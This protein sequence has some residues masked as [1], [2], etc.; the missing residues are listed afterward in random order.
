LTLGWKTAVQF[1]GSGELE[2]LNDY[3]KIIEFLVRQHFGVAVSNKLETGAPA[4]QATA[5]P[6][7]ILIAKSAPNGSDRDQ[8][9]E[10]ATTADVV[11]FVF[12]GRIYLS[13]PRWLTLSDAIW[14]KLRR[15]LGFSARETSAFAVIASKSCV[16]E[17]L[18]WHELG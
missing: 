17:K 16:P 11:F 1:V 4:I 6:C 9:K 13:Q 14:V 7:R 5:G 3:G 15:D 18:P 8:I 10:H 12:G 2:S